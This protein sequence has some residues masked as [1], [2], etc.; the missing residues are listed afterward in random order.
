MSPVITI[1]LTT[2]WDSMSNYC[3]LAIYC[4]GDIEYQLEFKLIHLNG[5]LMMNFNSDLKRYDE[6]LGY[7]Y[8]GI[9][10]DQ[11]WNSFVSCFQGVIGARDVSIVIESKPLRDQRVKNRYRLIT[12]DNAPH[13]TNEYL[14]SVMD[15]NILMDIPQPSASTVSDVMSTGT[16]LD[17]H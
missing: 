16:F 12:T 1:S 5:L 14:E 3:Y 7:A 13:L 17:S 8:S 15:A 9:Y 2:C 4:G 6:L 10:E 11:L